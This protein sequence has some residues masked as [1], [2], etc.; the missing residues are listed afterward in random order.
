[1]LVDVALREV[2]HDLGDF[3]DVAGGDLLDVQ[4]VTAGPVHLLFD[5]RSAQN[6]EDLRDLIGVDD[7]SH[8]HLLGV[9]HRHVDDQTIGRQHGQLQVFAGHSL[10]RS[11]GDCLNLRSAVSWIDDHVAD[12]ITHESSVKSYTNPELLFHQ[13]W[14]CRES[15]E[16]AK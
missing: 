6:L 9:F 3:V 8:A 1:M 2:A 13:G 16:K 15:S 7:I 4:L 14:T 10:N 12:L 11:L 5:D